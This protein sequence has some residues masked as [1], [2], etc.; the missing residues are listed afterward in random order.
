MGPCRVFTYYK[1]I[2]CSINPSEDVENLGRNTLVFESDWDKLPHLRK[3]ALGLP[4][5]GIFDTQIRDFVPLNDK[6]KAS[7]NAWSSCGSCH[8]DG[9]ADG[10][11]WIFAAGPRQTLPLDAF[12]AKDNPDDQK[13]VLWSAA[14]GSNTDFNNNSRGVQG[15]CGFASDA[16]RGATACSATAPANPAIYDH[17]ITQGASDA[18]DAQMLWVQTVRAPILPQPTDT[19]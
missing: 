2:Y 19:A 7:S 13:I 4:D 6:G 16:F 18:L 15:G 17:G 1:N 8:P 11:T 10:V 14:R 9:L 12:F 3:V 5:N